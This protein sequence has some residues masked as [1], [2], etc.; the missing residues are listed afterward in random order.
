MR[1]RPRWRRSTRDGR[2]GE[3]FSSRR[4]EGGLYTGPQRRMRYID[5]LSC[6]CGAGWLQ[7]TELWTLDVAGQDSVCRTVL[8]VMQCYV[9]RQCLSLML[10]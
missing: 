9:E 1:T 7:R 2:E 4:R 3:S 5:E 6:N 8:V 10:C